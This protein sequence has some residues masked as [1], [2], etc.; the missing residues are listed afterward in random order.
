MCVWQLG[1]T[2]RHKKIQY[3]YSKK[4]FTGRDKQIRIIGDRHNQHPDK[5][6]STVFRLL[7]HLLFC[8]GVKLSFAM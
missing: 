5:W 3:S 1:E 2:L 4:R 6:S 8:T 7:F